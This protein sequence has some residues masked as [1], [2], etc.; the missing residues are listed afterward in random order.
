MKLFMKETSNSAGLPNISLRTATILVILASL[1]FSNSWDG[2]FVF[3]D[4]EA[5][6]TNEDVRESSIS[7]IFKNDFWGTK[8]NHAQSHKSYRPLTILTFRGNLLARDFHILNITLHVAVSVLSLYMYDLLLDQSA[9]NIPFYAAILF[10][11]HPIHAEAVAGIVGRADILCAMFMW[12]SILLY[13]RSIY[14]ISWFGKWT[15]MFFCI[16]CIAMAM[17]SKETGITAIGLCCIYD[18]VVV[19][20]VLPMSTM[21]FFRPGYSLTK[22][23]ELFAAKYDH[24]ILRQAL[25]CTTAFLLLILRFSMMGF[26]APVFQPVDNPASFAEKLVVRVLNYNYI[27][28]LNAWLLLCPEWLCFDWA[29]G[30]VPLILGPDLRIFAILVL[31]VFLGSIFLH[32]ISTENNARH[33]MMGLALMFIPFL[34]ATNLFFNVGFVIAERTLYVPSAGFC[35]LIAIGLHRLT[36]YYSPKIVVSCFTALLVL[37]FTR[38]WVRS[39]EWNTE[40]TLFRSALNICPLNAKVHYN[41]AKNAADR[42]DFLHAELEYNEA[43]RLNPDYAQAMNNLGNLLKDMRKYEEAERLLKRA[44]ALQENFAAAWMNLGIVLAALSKYKES[45]E[46]YLIALSHRPKYPDC[47]YNLG[48][49][50]RC[51]QIMN[52][53]LEEKKYDKALMAWENATRQKTN[54]RRAWTNTILL[55]DDLGRR[56]QALSV[57]NKAL[58]YLPLEG[59]IYFYMANILGKAGKFE[60]AEQQFKNAILRD[61]EN[62]TFYTNLGVLY[63]R[64]NKRAKAEEMYKKALKIQPGLKSASDNLDKLKN[65]VRK[66]KMV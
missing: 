3:D 13:H 28:S 60:G 51:S 48:V 42:G 61:P 55:L 6:V 52:S 22:T 18:L 45:E 11:V 32:V 5:I 14:S 33:T 44:V 46:S 35:L 58:E 20:R 64:W 47:F 57:G 2:E 37:F 41:V 19:T 16:F 43:L 9:G 12:T 65:T 66:E 27:Y 31:W 26:S 7:D 34:P 40:K 63:H 59:S 39:G 1:C 30:C 36:K 21:S 54:H 4:S 10:A 25:L 62:P 17:L 24:L 15:N 50:V 56:E 23:R 8:L 49:L 53:Y 38:S 29:M